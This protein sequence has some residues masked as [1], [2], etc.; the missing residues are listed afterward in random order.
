[1]LKSTDKVCICVLSSRP[2]YIILPPTDSI[3][4]PLHVCSWLEKVTPSVCCTTAI[5]NVSFFGEGGG[6]EL[7]HEVAPT[8]QSR[9]VS[10]RL[11]SKTAAL[12]WFC[13]ESLLYFIHQIERGSALPVSQHLNST[14]VSVV[15]ILLQ[16][17]AGLAQS[18]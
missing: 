1:M 13:R 7:L 12:C 18:K 15:A 8:Y 14:Y 10:R 2:H 4:L 11:I 9:A 16:L 5:C 17:A 6:G 3:A